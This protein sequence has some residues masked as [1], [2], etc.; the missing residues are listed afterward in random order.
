MTLVFVG[1][2]RR[3]GNTVMLSA[4][5]ASRLLAAFQLP[6]VHSLF[7][8]NVPVAQA[9]KPDSVVKGGFHAK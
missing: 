3:K 4:S 8:W 7:T 1:A 9:F 5:T 2:R 6:K